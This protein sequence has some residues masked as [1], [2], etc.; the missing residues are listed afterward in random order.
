[1]KATN[2]AKGLT[3]PRGDNTEII[4]DLNLENF[5]VA[6]P[7]GVKIND[8]ISSRLLDIWDPAYKLEGEE[9]LGNRLFQ[10]TKETIIEE[11]NKTSDYLVIEK[12]NITKEIPEYKMGEVSN[13]KDII[14]REDSKY[15]PDSFLSDKIFCGCGRIT[16]K[17][18][19]KYDEKNE[20][21]ASND[22]KYL[23]NPFYVC[24]MKDDL[25]C[26]FCLPY[27]QIIREFEED[28]TYNYISDKSEDTSEEEEK[29]SEEE[30][31]IDEEEYEI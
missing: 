27:D 3:E 26:D 15:M 10:E 2:H 1:M 24:P 11:K 6:L 7:Y 21:T 14:V 16:E 31:L 12:L 20:E 8:P 29:H 23:G 5:K 17:R 19:A 25:K 13:Y 18:I 9:E 22:V 28:D 4:F 30:E